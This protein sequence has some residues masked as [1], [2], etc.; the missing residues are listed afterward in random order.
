M[1]L[2]AAAIAVLLAAGLT[3][4]LVP[5]VQS[6]SL[7]LGF[8]DIPSGRNIHRGPM[9]LGGGI[10]MLLAIVMPTLLVL[11]WVQ[12][13]SD[14]P[15]PSWLPDVVKANIAGA[16]SR[17]GMALIILGGAGV[18]CLLG[19]IDDLKRLGP[20]IKL[21]VQFGVAT[22]VVML[23]DLR[24]LTVLGQPASTVVS[25]LWMVVIINAMN[26]LDNMDGLSAGITLICSCALLAAAGSI[27]Q[28]FVSG[29][30]CLLIGATAG[31]LVFNFPPARIFMGDAGSLMLGYMLAVLSML[32]TYY[33]G[34]GDGRMMYRLLVPMVVLA[35]P[36][37]DFLSVITIRIREKRNPMV[38]DTRHF[39]HRLVKRGM[40]HRSA[41]LTIYLCTG[42]TSI[43]AVLLP[44]VENWAAVL[45]AGQA[46]GVLAIIAL[47]ESADGRHGAP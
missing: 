14:G 39:S 27:G 42:V 11:V 32:T 43:A 31:F 36:L 9:P 35:V 6:L 24:I 18:L 3:M 21:V 5:M 46:L 19:L 4:L 40:S 45:L 34:S 12:A 41:V 26:F 30:L 33:A 1:F 44:H 16:A 2:A 37:Y 7:R 20:W 17:A 8:V 38:G 47:L 28:L 29:W 22:A 23:A 10:A 15:P 13:W 25:V